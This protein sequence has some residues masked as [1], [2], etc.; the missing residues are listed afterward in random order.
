MEMTLNEVIEALSKDVED[1]N[2][3]G[4]GELGDDNVIVNIVTVVN[5]LSLLKAQ[6]P[7]E[8]LGFNHD[9]GWQQGKFYLCG[10][11][12]GSFFGQKVNFCPW[13]RTAVK[14]E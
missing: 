6:E 8:P 3:Y 7:I 14:W 13:C 5:A 1:F 11:C 9:T 12:G 10:E 2:K 4:S